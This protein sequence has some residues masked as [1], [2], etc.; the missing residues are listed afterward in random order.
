M[1]E[2]LASLDF[3]IGQPAR[4]ACNWLGRI[5]YTELVTESG[6]SFRERPL[7]ATMDTLT[8]AARSERM[9]RIRGKGTGPELMVRRMV[10]ALGYRFRLHRRGL[11]GHPDMV[12]PRHKAVVF[13]HGC[14]W[15][16]HPDPSCPL[17]RLPKSR[18][19][20]WKPKLEQNRARD[21]RNRHALITQGWRVLVVWECEL[22]D[23][24]RVAAKLQSFLSGENAR[25]AES[26]CSPE[27]AG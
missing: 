23:R 14:F 6:G 10:H 9:G 22:R 20:F 16:R 25:C 26:S 19:S 27:R 12:F 2:L 21:L 18:L 5:M 13:V 1:T 15:H 11:P 24:R 7:A 8:P 4:R 17:A 3:L